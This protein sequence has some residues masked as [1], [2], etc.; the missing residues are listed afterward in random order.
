[1]RH[2][3]VGYSDDSYLQG[4]SFDDCSNNVQYTVHLFTKVGFLLNQEKTDFV[5][6]YGLYLKLAHDNSETNTRESLKNWNRNF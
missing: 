3:N 2:T 4:T 5:T 6:S 1:M